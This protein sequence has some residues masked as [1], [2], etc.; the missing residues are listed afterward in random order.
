ME[1]LLAILFCFLLSTILTSILFFFNDES[2]LPYKRKMEKML[3]T[4][5]SYQKKIEDCKVKFSYKGKTFDVAVAWHGDTF[6]YGY[7]AVYINGNHIMTWHILHHLWS[8]SRLEEHHGDMKPSEEYEIIE[9]A[10][11]YAKKAN[12]EWWDK[13]L[14]RP[15]Y[16]D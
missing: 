3:E 11:K 2:C 7:Y 8:N 15:S 10:Y 1:I 6:H 16:F 4:I 13:K 9:A 14:S 12:N 5:R